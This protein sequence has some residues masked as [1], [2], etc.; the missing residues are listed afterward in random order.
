MKSLSIETVLTYRHRLM[1]VAILVL[2]TLM[3]LGLLVVRWLAVG[4]LLYRFLVWDLFLAWVP[5]WISLAIYVLHARGSS[6]RRLLLGLSIAW[7]L[8]FPNAPYLLTEFVH[9]GF[10]HDGAWWCDLVITIGFAWNGLMLGLLSL[11][12]M[13][14]VVRERFDARRGRWMAA[15]VLLLGSFGISLGRFERFNSW[16]VIRH[17]FSLAAG[18]ADQ[19]VHPEAYPRPFAIAV[20]LCAFMTLAYLA[21]WTLVMLNQD[22]VCQ[23]ERWTREVTA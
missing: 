21:L 19:F 22:E 5:F 16:D 23:S 7:L 3:S 8:F 14:K 13:Q 18:V 6:N 2:S 15:A 1:A 17:P 4:H 12:C 11:Y 9:L 10:R 20:L